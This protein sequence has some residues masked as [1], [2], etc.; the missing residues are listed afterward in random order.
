MKIRNFIFL[1]L[2]SIIIFPA[3]SGGNSDRGTSSDDLD[4]TARGAIGRLET[5]AVGP[6]WTGDG[7]RNIRLAVMAPELQG[8]APSYLPLYIQGLLNNNFGRFSAI[9]I[10]DRQNL[11]RIIQE[12]NIAA[13]GRF[14][15]RDFVRIGNLVNA[16]FFL[17][18]TIQR[19]SGNRFSLQLSV[20]EASTGV[21]RATFMREGTLAQLEGRATL[22]NEA[23]A[24]LLTQLGIQLTEAGRRE[25]LAGNISVV[26]S[27]AGLA[28]GITA[29]A[30]GSEVEALLNF[31]QAI[32]F[33]PA[34]LEALSRLNTLSTTISG[35]TISQRIINDTQARDR[36]LEAFRETARFFNEHPPFEIIF[37][38]N[39]IQIGET[40]FRRRT[41]NLGMRISLDSSKAGFDALNTLLSGLER[42]GRREAWGFL[43]WPFINIQGERG[44]TIFG[45]RRSFSYKIDVALVNENG[46]RLGNSSITLNSEVINFNSG[47]RSILPPKSV[48][49]IV[50]FNNIRTD[51]L[52]S[53]LTIVITA[54]NGISSSNLAATGNMRIKTGGLDR[55]TGGVIREVIFNSENNEIITFSGD[56]K[57][58]F[59][60]TNTGRITKIYEIDID[61]NE[62]FFSAYSLNLLYI[63]VQNFENDTL[64]IYNM[65]TRKIINTLTNILGLGEAISPDGKQFVIIDRNVDENNII[66]LYDTETGREIRTLMI[67][68]NLRVMFSQDNRQLIIINKN[69]IIIQDINTGREV[70]RIATDHTTVSNLIFST[71]GRQV[72]TAGTVDGYREI[73][74]LWDV[75]TGREIRTFIGHSERIYPICFSPDGRQIA[76][77]SDDTTIKLWDVATGR[78]I[79]AFTGHL[80][81][82]YSINFSSDGRQ[83]VSGSADTTIRF[84][85]TRTG[86]SYNIIG[87]GQQ[88][89]FSLENR[90]RLALF[91]GIELFRQNNFNQ[92][93]IEF[94][95]SIQ[96]YPSLRFSEAYLWRG[97][98]Y[99]EIRNYNYAINDLS[100]LIR[101]Y[102]NNANYYRNRGVAYSNNR[103]HNRA[104]IDFSNAIRLEPNSALAYLERGTT[105]GIIGQNNRA[106]S[107]LTD[108]I[109]L[110]PNS[111]L[112][113]IERGITYINMNQY[114][115]A[116]T[117]FNNA[118]RLNPNSARAYHQRGIAYDWI[119]NTRQ[120]QSDFETALRLE[121][122]N[123]GYRQSVERIRNRR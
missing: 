38:P 72:I 27:Q 7:G 66:K 15:D 120:A 94:S 107:D 35:G 17:F 84:W 114:N 9:N 104:I 64:T 108:A 20:T 42:T 26:Q 3:F 82:V 122:N 4:I 58:R 95:L 50:R 61:E 75:A 101:L 14:S 12:Q 39:L 93:I 37:D 68:G 89:Q 13:S 109:R 8:E 79:R 49:S 32:I 111:V 57:I 106:I 2:F 55:E 113:Y 98:S 86:N 30:G 53:S 85:D 76:S 73:F 23:T 62:A 67:N 47:D 91:R 6:M 59:W 18:G 65:E 41:A 29:Q 60:D 103:E 92:A 119:N 63:M 96:L 19:L 121:P 51:A 48:E 5:A 90:S 112:A 102:P 1:V 69:I 24:E 33:D 99:S 123:T 43:G 45:G 117:D 40:D 100:I 16:Q 88:Q 74:K 11:D 54:V 36:W 10:I 105:Y 56:S 78:E 22:I 21:R 81:S 46:E 118:I 25:L 77:A 34:Q 116:I 31:S 80:D 70:R 28:R 87:T 71:D 52:T 97:V 44:T 110:D 115:L 83:I